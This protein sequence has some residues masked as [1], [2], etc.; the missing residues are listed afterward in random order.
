M[1]VLV[2]PI[3]CI[4]P[5]GGRGA[6]GSIIIKELVV[7]TLYADYLRS[8]VIYAQQLGTLWKIVS[9]RAFKPTLDLF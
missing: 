4:K 7:L 5:G 6:L 3:L 1:K 9:L 8:I 2:V